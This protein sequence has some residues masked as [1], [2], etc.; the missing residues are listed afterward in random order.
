M[1][2]AWHLTSRPQG[3]PTNENFE[4]R[5]VELPPVA[6]NSDPVCIVSVPSRSTVAPDAM[7]S[8]PLLPTV[9]VV[10]VSSSVWL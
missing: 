6:P 10:A 1:A 5:D 4:L 7:Y 2:R 9:S 3:T 8:V